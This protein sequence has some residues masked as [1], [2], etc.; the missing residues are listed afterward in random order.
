MAEEIYKIIIRMNEQFEEQANLKE[1][2]YKLNDSANKK[3]EIKR[4]CA[5]WWKRK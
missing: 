5:G 2:I 1:D 3:T 4:K